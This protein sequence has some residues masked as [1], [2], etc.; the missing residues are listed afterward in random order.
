MIKTRFYAKI[1]NYYRF[2]FSNNYNPYYE[3]VCTTRISFDFEANLIC[4]VTLVLSNIKPRAVA[5]KVKT[6]RT[7]YRGRLSRQ[8]HTILKVKNKTSPI[9]MTDIVVVF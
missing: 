3:H 6:L 2:L 4:A 9:I 5:E 8:T 7:S 1:S